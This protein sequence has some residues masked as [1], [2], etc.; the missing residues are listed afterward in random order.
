MV[1]SVELISARRLSRRAWKPGEDEA[2]ETEK[3]VLANAGK[4]LCGGDG[5]IRA[6]VR[7]RGFGG[8]LRCGQRRG[9]WRSWRA[10][11]GRFAEAAQQLESARATVGDV[12]ASLRDYAEGI[13]ASPERLAEIEDRLARSIG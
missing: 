5:R 11:N 7:R 3:R 4:A 1:D 2:M 10:T 9:T 13:D 6:A 12:G 8:S